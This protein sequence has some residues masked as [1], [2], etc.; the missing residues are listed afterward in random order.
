MKRNGFM[1][2]ASPAAALFLFFCASAHALGAASPE[3]CR[4]ADKNPQRRINFDRDWKFQRG[5]P[6]NAQAREF[7]DSRWRILDLPHDWSIEALP[8]QDGKDVIGPFSRRS[9]GAWDTGYVV[10]GEA[11]YRKNLFLGKEDEGKRIRLY[12]EGVYN[13]AEVYVNG[14]KAAF[15][16]YGYSSFKV[17]LT[18]FCRFGEPNAIAVKVVNQGRNSRWYSGSGIYRHVWLEKTP[19]VHLDEWDVFVDASRVKNGKAQVQFQAVVRN[20]SSMKGSG[21]LTL[22]I[23]SPEGETAHSETMR[24][25]S[26]SG[27]EAKLETSF[28]IADPQLWSQKTPNMYEAVVSLEFGGLKDRLV[29]PFGIRTLEFSA[30]KGFLLNGE[31][32]LLKGGCLHH[33]NGLLGSAAIERAEERKLELLKAN[34]FNAVRCSHN[35][36]TNHF[37]DLCD[38]MGILVVD[39]S[40]DMWRKPK[41]SGDD[42][43]RWFDE[44]S[45]HDLSTMVRRDRNHPS[46]IMWSVGN[47][48]PE[49]GEDDGIATMERLTK[50]VKSLDSTRPTTAAVHMWCARWNDNMERAMRHL[51]VGGYNYPDDHCV[52]DHEAFPNR[53]MFLSETFPKT[54]WR[55]WDLTEK[56]PY[57]IGDFV[58]T[59]FDYLGEV[60]LAH[61]LYLAPGEKG[62][63]LMEWPWYNAWCG[64]L[65]FCG[66][67][68]PQSYFR[69][70]LWGLREISLAA[71]PPIPE[72]KTEDVSLWGWPEEL[73]SW[74][75]TGLEGKTM[76]VNVY[77]RSKKA[78]LYLNGRL[79]GEKDVDPLKLVATF[80]VPYE[81]GS[82]KAV[83]VENGEEGASAEL[84]TTGKPVRIRLTADRNEIKASKDDLSYVKIELLDR[85]GNLVQDQD[86]ALSIVCDGAG[87]VAAAGNGAFQDMAS[88]RSLAPKTF[89]GRAIAILQPDEKKGAG[90][91]RLTVS[92]EGLEGDSIVVRTR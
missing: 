16:A 78:R 28:E 74:N 67:K 15:N 6:E 73:L 64:D 42:Y 27:E 40:F 56:K 22:R 66:D 87:R 19:A 58:W 41:L 62:R 48:I 31:P 17:D 39:E 8:D 21:S 85:D 72:G 51:D 12:F 65:D 3:A 50:I 75:W 25:E 11:W 26:A 37:L 18:P 89:R 30:E 52:K 45:E 20:P 2:S 49:C 61:N 69:D 54:I 46:V 76:K 4:T 13:Q 83:C 36:P 81:P 53:V 24:F 91:I 9:V 71:Q 92:S 43:H 32:T 70:V 59:A 84:R 5:N 35:P 7:D 34:G 57:V 63:H 68:K 1:L 80:D 77:S 60:G 33:D 14:E 38:R 47:E 55:T 44:W 10:G 90:E 23:V 86:A 82:L 79:I 88:F 29:V